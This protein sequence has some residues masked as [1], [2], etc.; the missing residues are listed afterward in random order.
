M[1]LHNPVSSKIYR[2]K[3][4][5]ICTD[6]SRHHH[7]NYKNHS[8]FKIKKIKALISVLV[9]FLFCH[10]SHGLEYTFHLYNIQ[11]LIRNS[12]FFNFFMNKPYSES[13][14]F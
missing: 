5:R 12:F 3:V 13:Y 6:L 1:Y 4:L 11:H 9:V 2:S 7:F 10:A 14:L 8:V